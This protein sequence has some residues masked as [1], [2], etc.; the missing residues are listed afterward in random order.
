MRAMF[1]R[2]R[3]PT[4]IVA[5]LLLALAAASVEQRDIGW[6]EM[7]H[8]AQVRAFDS[9]TPRIDRWYLTTGDRAVYKGHYY[10]DKA[11]GLAL[12][13]VPVYRA[14]R[15]LRLQAPSNVPAAL[16]WLVLWGCTLPFLVIMLLAHRLVEREDPGNGA[17]VAMML[18]AGTLLLPFATM[19]FSHVL[20]ACLGFAAFCLLEHERRRRR[21][22]ADG[23]GLGLL[24]FGGALCGYAVGSEFP[25]A[26]LA[27]LLALFVAWRRSPIRA[28]AAYAVGLCAGLTPLL[29]Y[30]WWAFGSPLHLSYESVAANSRG[31]LGLVPPSMHAALELLF[32]NVGLFIVTPVCAAAIAGILVLHREGKREMAIVSGAVVAAYFIYNICYYAPFG[33]W[34]PGPRFLITMLPFMAVPLAAAYRRAP[35]STLALGAASAATMIAATTTTP[36]LSPLS[37]TS[38]WWTM[39]AHGSYTAPAISIDAFSLFIGL[40]VVMLIRA[41]PRPHVTR[42][43]FALAGIALGG[44]FAVRQGAPPLLAYDGTGVPWGTVT[45]V[46][47][48]A[49]AATIWWTGQRL[50]RTGR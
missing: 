43:D 48:G 10:S 49:L 25:L 2:W 7:S 22:R 11:P 36:E 20:S 46:L 13:T 32:G 42:R 45:L 29:A 9:G 26:I 40:A 15:S 16:H 47:L 37:S 39:L 18:G 12:W 14:V 38:T 34:V 3:I 28:L 21:E 35:I 19:F 8:L 50:R 44:W 31:L 23:D 24:A 17:V 33:G 1:P 6:N 4:G 30:D 5:I 27:A 41:T